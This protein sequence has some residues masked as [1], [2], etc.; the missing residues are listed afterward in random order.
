MKG[1]KGEEERERGG[2]GRD[3]RGRGQ[4]WKG[5]GGKVK[6]FIGFIH[7]IHIHYHAASEF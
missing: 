6:M 5:E 2:E 4:G 3:G 1:E 7:A